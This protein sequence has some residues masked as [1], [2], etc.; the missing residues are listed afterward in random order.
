M[1]FVFFVGNHPQNKDAN[2]EEI[3]L[4]ASHLYGDLYITCP[5]VHLAAKLAESGS[6]GNSF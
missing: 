5:A 4:V 6:E 3:L 2:E 1:F